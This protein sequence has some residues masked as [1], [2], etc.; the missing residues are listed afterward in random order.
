VYVICQKLGW[1]RLSAGAGGRCCN[2]VLKSGQPSTHALNIVCDL[3]KNGRIQ[4]S[5]RNFVT[6]RAPNFIKLGYQLDS[7]VAAVPASFGMPILTIALK[8]AWKSAQKCVFF[9]CSIFHL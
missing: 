5:V 4:F 6:M 1:F 9:D 2:K 3:E 8:T 7:D